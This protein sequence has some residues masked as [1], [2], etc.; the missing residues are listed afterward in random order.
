MS[1]LLETALNPRSVAIIGASENIHKIGGR[2]ILFMKRFGFKGT[3]YPI[4]PTRDQVQGLKSYPSL[5]ELPE[6]PEMVLIV[7]AGQAAVDAVEECAERGVKTVVVIASGYGE[8]DQVGRDIQARWRELAQTT[9]MRIIGPNT[10]GIANFGNGTIAGF[11]TMFVEVEPQDGP[12]AVVSQSGGMSS[13]A[14]GLLRAQN[15]GVRYVHATGNEADVSVSDMAWAVAH[16][17]TIKLL[18]LYVEGLQHPELLAQ[19]AAYAKSRDLPIVVVK[20]ARTEGGKRAALCH[21]GSLPNDDAQ[22]QQ[23]FDANGIYRVKDTHA[24]TLAAPAYLKAWRPKGKR[25][26]VISNSGASCVMA[27]DAAADLGLEL[28]TLAKETQTAVAKCLPGFA[29]TANPIDITAALLSNSAL[30]SEVLPLV[31]KD[32]AADMFFINIPVAGAGYD[33]QAFARDTAAF[34]K[35]TGKPVV[36]AAWQEPV[37]AV[38]RAHGVLTFANETQGLGV[39]AQIYRHT[40]MLSKALI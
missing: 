37:A 19:T 33:V 40:A 34:E 18:L 26:V 23:F 4:N 1:D 10:Q 28:A 8:I 38:F 35:A 25:I 27:A 30:F 20:A 16:D 22:M 24:L 6:A 2:P 9:G 14:Y 39:L 15:I 13:V 29:T 31:A 12:V 11:S 36:V 32:P 5:R 21:T 17:P 7:V 3:I